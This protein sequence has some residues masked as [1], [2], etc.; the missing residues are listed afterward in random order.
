MELGITCFVRQL[1]ESA[2]GISAIRPKHTL[3]M[4]REVN[5]GSRKFWIV[6]EPHDL[7]TAPGARLILE[8]TPGFG[9]SARLLKR[10][11]ENG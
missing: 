4:S 8:D 5:I 7:V 3:S 6:S 10:L 2:Y 11:D 1:W 9:D